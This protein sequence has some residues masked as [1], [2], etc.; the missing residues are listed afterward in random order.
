MSILTD[1]ALSGSIYT[2]D[3]FSN[4][5]SL[6]INDMYNAKIDE[7]TIAQIAY[8]WLSPLSMSLLMDYVV[9]GN[10]LSVGEISKY[11]S[12]GDQADDVVQQLYI[13]K[14]HRLSKDKLDIIARPD[15]KNRKIIRILLEKEASITEDDINLLSK[16]STN[17]KSTYVKL[18]ITDFINGKIDIEKFRL[19][20][21]VLDSSGNIELIKELYY[22]LDSFN[23]TT[24][25]NFIKLSE[26]LSHTTIKETWLKNLKSFSEND[27][28]KIINFADKSVIFSKEDIINSF[29]SKESYKVSDITLCNKYGGADYT[30]YLASGKPATDDRIIALLKRLRTNKISPEIYKAYLDK[31]DVFTLIFDTTSLSDEELVIYMNSF[32]KFGTKDVK[33]V[34]DLCKVEDTKT[35]AE[36]IKTIPTED[37]SDFITLIEKSGTDSSILVGFFKDKGLIDSVPTLVAKYKVVETEDYYEEDYYDEEEFKDLFVSS[38]SFVPVSLDMGKISISLKDTP[39]VEIITMEKIEDTKSSVDV[40]KYL[41][42]IEEDKHDLEYTVRVKTK[43]DLKKA[44]K[45]SIMLIEGIPEFKDYLVDLNNA[46]DTLETM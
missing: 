18:A 3:Q 34:V 36:M 5:Q 27:L 12:Y 33:A 42:K 46:L 26:M 43:A 2:S 7:S 21:K 10:K 15:I 37:F 32:D 6:V 31:Y 25:N 45:R 39:D 41:F 9:G 4:E 22:N 38:K 1:K 8:P 24:I 30:L 19:F 16:L 20:L 11:Q 13:G 44:I 35:V 29:I 40:H 17:T 28:N 14:L 23:T